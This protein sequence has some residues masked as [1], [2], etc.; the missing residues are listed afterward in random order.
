MMLHYGGLVCRF[1]LQFT[2]GRRVSSLKGSIRV[3]AYIEALSFF[4]GAHL[5]VFLAHLCFV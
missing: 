3:K 5:P 2:L 4:W 1:F